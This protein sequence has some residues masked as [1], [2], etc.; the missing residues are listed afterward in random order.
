MLGHISKFI[1]FDALTMV[2]LLLIGSSQASF[3]QETEFLLEGDGDSGITGYA[4]LLAVSGNEAK[5]AVKGSGC[6]GEM[7]AH[8]SRVDRLT[9][10]LSSTG[11]GE[12]CKI[13][14][15]EDGNGLIETIQGPGCSYY[16]GAVCGFSGRF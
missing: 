8:F 7:D 1:R 2:L 11:G 10:L 9:W 12:R 6:L 5:I 3:A 13:L 15:R 4:L 14:L 16:H